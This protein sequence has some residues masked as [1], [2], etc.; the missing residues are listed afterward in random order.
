MDVDEYLNLN[1]NI[2]I[3]NQSSSSLLEN[4]KPDEELEEIKNRGNYLLRQEL[5]DKT[6]INTPNGLK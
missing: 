3:I 4:E 5:K 6:P 2:K 1:P